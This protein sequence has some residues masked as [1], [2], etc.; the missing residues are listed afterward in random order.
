MERFSPDDQPGAGR[1]RIEG[2]QAGQLGH[3]AALSF[4]PVLADGGEPHL[5]DPNGV[6][7]GRL[8]LGVPA[9]GDEEPHVAVPTGDQEALVAPGRVGPDDD[10]AGDE[11][12]VVAKTVPGRRL[13]RQLGDGGVEDLQVV[14]HGVGPG[15][16]RPQE[17][18]ERLPGGVGHRDLPTGGHENSPR[19]AT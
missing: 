9:G 6:E 7:D 4:L 16:A 19:M 11:I 1:Q 12:S 8:H 15:V 10:P 3:G 18:R 13:R 17:A 14:G 5:F 2:H